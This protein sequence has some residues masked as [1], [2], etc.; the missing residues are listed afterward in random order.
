[1]TISRN[2]IISILL[3]LVLL[4]GAVVGVLLLGGRKA[5]ATPIARE[6]VAT[7]GANPFMASVG[8]DLPTVVQPP[9]TG[10]SFP[11]N[12]PGLYG[13]TLKKASCDP[14]QM[15]SFLQANPDKGS[16]WA[17]VL[18]IAPSDIPS[19]VS[20][21]TPVILRSDTA[22]TNHGFVAGHATSFPAILEAGTAVLVDRFG[23]PVTKCYCGNPLTPPPVYA[24]PSYVG[25]PWVGFSPTNIT[26]IKQTTVEINIFTLVDPATGQA[27][28]RPRATTGGSD[29]PSGTPVPATPT[30]PPS[31]S[32]PQSS[33]TLPAVTVPTTS[34]PS[35]DITSQGAV[36]ASSSFNSSFPPRLAVDGDP[37][38]S[39]FSAGDRDGN[40]STFTWRAPSKE[41]IG[42]IMVAGNAR[43]AT[44]AFRSGFGFKSTEVRV[45]DTVGNIVYRQTF[46]GPGAAAEDIV[47]TPNVIG[48][49][50]EL[51]L[52]G[53]EN[54]TCGGISTLKVIG[55]AA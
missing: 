29:Q 44:P 54:P 24:Q 53:H 19:Y 41:L 3:V 55:R 28:Q 32:V 27:F 22:V 10:G 9:N 1:M 47:A 14:Q 40:T 42:Q 26:I 25:P 13:G 16:A 51:L 8:T 35:V 20:G 7:A 39:W 31:V 50:V 37:T 45:L 38:T 49:T 43:N 30:T 33:Q 6:P 23:S 52:S 11:A 17:S 34:Q 21:L 36:S 5:S 46:P 48:Q 4:L 15:V 18:G 2:A 12:T